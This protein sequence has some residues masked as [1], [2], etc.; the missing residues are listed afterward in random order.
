L[1]LADADPSIQAFDTYMTPLMAAATKGHADVVR[2]LLAYGAAVDAKDA[3]G[4]TALDVALGHGCADCVEALMRAGCDPNSSRVLKA[5][6][7]SGD[8]LL[9][10]F[11][12]NTC[13]E[14]AVNRLKWL[15]SKPYVGVVVK[16]AGLVGGAEHNGRWAA[17]RRYKP[18]KQRFELELLEN[19][20]RMD[21][22]PSNFVLKRLPAGTEVVT[23]GLDD[24]D[25]P[26]LNSVRGSVAGTAKKTAWQ[27]ARGCLTTLAASPHH[28]KESAYKIS[29]GSRYINSV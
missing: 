14:D 13:G 11:R 29:V 12:A 21:V 25:E 10:K 4:T 15:M 17:V 2:L 8:K 1:L 27:G 5:V 19:R 3:D 18:G 20:K 23:A 24:K 22:R 7:L 9:C 26:D 28:L 16:L 6:D